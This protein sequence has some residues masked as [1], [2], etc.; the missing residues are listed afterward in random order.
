MNNYIFNDS[1]TP[2]NFAE[3]FKSMRLKKGITQQDAV[4]AT[5]VSAVSYYSQV[6]LRLKKP[7]PYDKLVDLINLLDI[8]ADSKR[9]EFLHVAFRER[10]SDGDHKLL[11]DIQD[12]RKRL[13]K[14]RNFDVDESLINI[15][16]ILS[17]VDHDKYPLV[18]ELL[19]H[20]KK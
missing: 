16:D 12:T 1:W 10:L 4:N 2:M 17:D 19:K 7:P 14:N 13:M 11:M 5:N 18:E 6:E 9:L 8:N 3:M 20:F 15:M